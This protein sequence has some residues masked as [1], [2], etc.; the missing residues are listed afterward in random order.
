MNLALVL[1]LLSVLPGNGQK[2]T[3]G[4]IVSVLAILAM[5]FLPL[6][7]NAAADMA[8]K[9]V[10]GGGALWAAIGYI[11]RLLKAKEAKKA[12]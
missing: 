3:T 9:I 10:A 6:D 7:Q 1:K 8:A 11:H 2:F 4:T 5:Q 12:S